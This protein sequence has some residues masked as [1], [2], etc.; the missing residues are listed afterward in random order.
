MWL[1]ASQQCAAHSSQNEFRRSLLRAQAFLPDERWA[2]APGTLGPRT[3]ELRMGPISVLQRFVPTVGC[4]CCL[5]F[6]GCFLL[7]KNGESVL[8]GT[9]AA[10]APS[11]EMLEPVLKFTRQKLYGVLWASGGP[12][13]LSQHPALDQVSEFR[14]Q[15]GCPSPAMFEIISL[16]GALLLA[17]PTPHLL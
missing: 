14:F 12:A 9:L 13:S 3:W 7:Q 4:S 8:R 6:P 15:V 1:P 5:W 11:L 2:D 10:L 16:S 17:S